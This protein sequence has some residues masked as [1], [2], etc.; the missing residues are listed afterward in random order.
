MAILFPNRSASCLLDFLFDPEEESGTF[1]LNV[2]HIAV[3]GL[4]EHI[5]AFDVHP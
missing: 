1:F 4:F 3:L 5:F 2:G